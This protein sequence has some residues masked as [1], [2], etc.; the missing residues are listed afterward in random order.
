[1]RKH[2]KNAVCVCKPG[3]RSSYGYCKVSDL[4]GYI[5]LQTIMDVV[6]M[7]SGKKGLES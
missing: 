3:L 7:D 2:F 1:M 6:V 5:G 4:T